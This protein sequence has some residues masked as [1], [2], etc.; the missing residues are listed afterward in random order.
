MKVICFSLLL[1]LAPLG[2][3]GAAEPVTAE[4]VQQNAKDFHI[5]DVRS[6]EEYA[7]FD[8]AHD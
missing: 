2:S 5:V 7:G 1:L 6:N 4:Q 3:A 8:I